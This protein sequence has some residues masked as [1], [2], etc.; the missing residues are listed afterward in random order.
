MEPKIEAERK[1]RILE[2]EKAVR[3]WRIEVDKAQRAGVDVGESARDL[4]AAEARLERLKR[5]Y[6]EGK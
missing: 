3:V 4:A 6:L 5:V 1:A 2:L